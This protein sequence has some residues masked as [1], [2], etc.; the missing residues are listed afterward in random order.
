MAGLHT[1]VT[2]RGK[3]KQAEMISQTAVGVLVE[4]V[5]YRPVGYKNV[6]LIH[7]SYRSLRGRVP[8]QV[9]ISKHSTILGM[10]RE[11]PIN[12]CVLHVSELL[13][14]LKSCQMTI[15]SDFW[16]LLMHRNPAHDKTACSG[17]I[18]CKGE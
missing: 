14:N 7:T 5:R 8:I 6:Y 1:K 4:L 17:Q 12:V 10:I 16:S 9:S 18:Q 3:L 2:I 15:F 13:S 11:F